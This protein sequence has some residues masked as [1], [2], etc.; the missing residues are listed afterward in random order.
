M[1]RKQVTLEFLFRASPTILYTFITTPACLIRWFCDG[2]DIRGN[3]YLFSWGS[4]TEAAE[5]IDDIEEE[6][7]RFQWESAESD[8]E[9]LE[10]RISESPV[11][12]ETILEIVDYCD[13]DELEDQKRY[14]ETLMQELRKETGG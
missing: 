2:V 3:T 5:L 12:N 8:D 11:T 7:V 6:R 4:S 10:F 13:A 1:E 14:W 9:F